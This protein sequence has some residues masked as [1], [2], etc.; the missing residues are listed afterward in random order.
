M[1][2]RDSPMGGDIV[3]T[4][5][6]SPNFL[7]WAIRDANGGALQR[8]QIVKGSVAKMPIGKP[9]EQVYDV[10]CSDGLSP[11]PITHRCPDNGAKVNLSD[12]SVSADRG[13]SELKVVWKDPDFNE[14]EKAFYY[15]RVLEN[16]SCRWSTWDAIK[17]GHKPRPDLQ[18]T[19]QERAW[20]SPIWYTPKEN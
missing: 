3:G 19:I 18:A 20:S 1:C 2:I 9:N 6:N 14:N 17:N 16:P 7:V 15:V 12:C 11:D 10:S 5:E 4:S 8:I 13:S